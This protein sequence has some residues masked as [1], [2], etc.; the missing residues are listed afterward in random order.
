MDPTPGAGPKDEPKQLIE[1]A[2]QFK[3]PAALK[4][5][6]EARKVA[7]EEALKPLVEL[8]EKPTASQMALA[9]FQFKEAIQGMSD[10]WREGKK[11]LSEG[12]EP[13]R[14][15]FKGVILHRLML[16]LPL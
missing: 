15:Y 2:M 7:P 11:G 14:A 5:K 9:L 8:P 4:A 1:K 10:I 13:F 16:A 3:N 6:W 12:L